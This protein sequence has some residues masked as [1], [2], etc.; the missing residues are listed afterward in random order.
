M[1]FDVSGRQGDLFTARFSPE[2]ELD[3]WLADPQRRG[4]R[5]EQELWT[6]RQRQGHSLHEISYRACFKPQLPH[7]FITRLTKPGDRVFDPF[8]GRGTTAVE[9][10]LLGRRVAAND[11]N[12]L[13]AILA[14][15]RIEPPA[16]V[17]VRERLAA[18][19]FAHAPAAAA[20]DPDL[21]PFYHPQTERQIRALRHYLNERRSRD[22]EDGVD[23]WL[24]MVA[25][26]RLTGHSPGFFSVYT[27][28]PNQATTPSRQREINAK[29]GQEPPFRDVPAII[30]KKSAQLLSGLDET[31]RRRLCEL[32]E[33]AWFLNQRAQD[34]AGI[35]DECMQLTVTSPPFLDVVQYS[36]DNWLRC[37]FN[38]I[39]ATAVA[40]QMS[41]SRSLEVWREEM[42][43]SL[44][45][46]FRITRKGGYVAFEVGEVR[47]GEIKLDEIIAPLGESVGFAVK[48]V[49][50]NQQR[51]TKTAN[52]W[53]I[54]NNRLGTNTNRIVLFIKE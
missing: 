36:E 42:A 12:P 48:A 3:C 1:L 39:D 18:I 31:Q 45:E 23:R 2:S 33:D 9:A 46:L 25:T 24:R 53:G 40:S 44:R 29:R 52:I 17:E 35:P 20:T 34:L 8:A 50:I 38:G 5:I 30:L 51:F 11:V 32:A 27:L 43:A 41:V 16:L 49:L 10:A 15:P 22:E 4:L 28:P 14:R 13:S 19:D 7:F 6:S 26:N 54:R 21:S 47:N 37:W